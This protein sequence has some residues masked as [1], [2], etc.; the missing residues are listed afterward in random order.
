[1]RVQ[2]YSLTHAEDVKACVEAGVDH[3]GVA[4][5]DQDLPAAISNE[6]A[7]SLF[8][9]VPADRTTVA[10]TVETDPAAI[11]RYARAV[12]PDILHI[13]SDTEAVGPAACERVRERLA[14]D[15]SLMKAIDVVDESAVS[16][17]R[18]FAP[19]ADWL[20]LDTATTAVDGVGA[21]G[22]THDWSISRDIV[23]AVDT[24]VMLAGGLSP[25]NVAEAI[26]K[27]RP[28]GVDSFT[29]TS[30]TEE[31]KDHDAV[32]AFVKAARQSATDIGG[33]T[34]E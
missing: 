28:A 3:I 23:T 24:P 22:E 31:R 32:A 16:A 2:I 27:V 9:L 10:L 5:G 12:E 8:S 11:L 6:K 1:M 15:I 14:P 33:P 13:C 7:R 26:Q 17:A 20:I 29:H 34:C 21:S 30:R 19:V 4:A 25:S 18:R